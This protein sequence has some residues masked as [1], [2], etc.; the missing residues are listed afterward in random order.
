MRIALCLYGQPR[1]YE[2]GYETI[3]K[4]ILDKYNSVDVFFHAWETDKEYEAS[5]WRPVNKNKVNLEEVVNL[6][7]PKSYLIEKSMTFFP[8]LGNGYDKTSHKNNCSNILSQFYS[9]TSVRNV[10]LNYC[11]TNS[12]EYD[13][14]IVTRFDINIIKLPSVL[15]SLNISFCMFHQDRPLIFNDNMIISGVENFIKL[16]NFY[17]NLNRFVI[18][19]PN[20]KNDYGHMKHSEYIL[21]GTAINAEEFLS[22]SLID[23]DLFGFTEKNID[24]QTELF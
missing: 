21:N 19:G 7:K 8:P 24:L 5:P 15:N 6:Y 11:Q 23:N 3:K 2:K 16:F 4:H 17:P 12:K 22:A 9:R 18:Q 20:T 10:F 13:I 1:N 14:V